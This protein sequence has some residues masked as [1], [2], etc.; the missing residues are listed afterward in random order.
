MQAL[1]RDLSPRLAAHGNAI[2]QNEALFARLHALYV[3]RDTLG[4]SVDAD[5]ACWCAC[6]W[7]SSAAGAALPKAERGA[8]LPRLWRNS[9][10]LYTRF[11]QNVLADEAGFVLTLTTPEDLAGLPPFVREA[12][13][14]AARERGLPEGTSAITLFARRWARTLSDFFP[15]DATCASSYG[16]PAASGAPTM[17]RMTTGRW[18]HGIVA[19]RQEQAT[20]LGYAT[21][22][23]LPT[24]GSH[25]AVCRRPSMNC[26][27]A[28]GAG[29]EK[30]PS[31]IAPA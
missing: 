21:Y 23:R 12:A 28:R 20:L 1:E 27:D 29:V 26:F 8:L 9:S 31:T 5:P 14:Q 13:S 16:A 22:R 15:R 6:I 18:R 10:A 3:K 2:Y 17:E 11:G 7:I 24:G 30:R 4:L 25:G 19:L